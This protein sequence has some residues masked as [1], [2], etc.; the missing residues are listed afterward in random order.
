MDLRRYGLIVLI[1]LGLAGCGGDDDPEGD[2][3]A[4][5]GYVPYLLS[6]P[7]VS[8]S[9]NATTPTSYDVTVTVEANGPTGVAFASLW[10]I[11]VNN[12]GNF[13]FLDLI[14]T[15]GTT[16][17]ATTMALL[18]LAPGQ[19]YID[20]IILED[21]DVFADPVVRT[22]WYTEDF[23]FSSNNY[24]VDERELVTATLEIPFYNFGVSGIGVTRFTLP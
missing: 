23:F 2:G 18:P 16:W 3:D 1:T 15:G 12:S 10:I 11:D 22:G 6:A 21:A 9:A 20:D 4:V 14:N 24:F 8:F 7:T 5:S 19:Y 13:A 17:T